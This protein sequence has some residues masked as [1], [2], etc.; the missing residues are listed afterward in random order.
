MKQLKMGWTCIVLYN[1]YI[2]EIKIQY[3]LLKIIKEFIANNK[4]LV[5][6]S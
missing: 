1:S 3:K 6:K 2:I 4:V 5:T